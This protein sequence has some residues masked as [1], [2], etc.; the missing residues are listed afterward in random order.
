MAQ[1]KTV[2]KKA[3]E[4]RRRR[5]AAKKATATRRHRA[6]GL[7]AAA[8]ASAE[9]QGRRPQPHAIAKIRFVDTSSNWRL[10]EY[11]ALDSASAQVSM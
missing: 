11:A 6:A 4:T 1:S 2:G 5:S 8:L 7:K 9:P 3:A 10:T